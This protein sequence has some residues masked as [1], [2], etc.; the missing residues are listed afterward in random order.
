MEPPPDVTESKIER[1]ASI[2]F[3]SKLNIAFRG[4]HDKNPL[5]DM[6]CLSTIYLTI[7]EYPLLIPG[8]FAPKR[9]L[10]F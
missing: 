2:K 4:G 6:T 5:L 1:L 9:R 10:C 3:I 8:I 7:I